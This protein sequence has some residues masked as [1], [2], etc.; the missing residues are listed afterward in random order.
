MKVLECFAFWL[1]LAVALAIF[2]GYVPPYHDTLAMLS[3]GV[4][5][6]L[7][8]SG[9]RIGSHMQIQSMAIVFLLNYAF[10]PAITLAPAILMNDNAYWTGFVIMVSMPPA[11]AL[12][13][14][15]KILKADTELAMSGEVFLYLASL[16]M[17]P[18]MI[19]MLAGKSVSI[20]PVVWSLFTLIL[21]P[22]GV[23]RV[24]GR[25]I[26]A[27]SGWVK[28]TINV[29]FF[30][31]I[32]LVFSMNRAMIIK[33]M[34]SVPVIGAICA[35]RTL[36][37]SL[38]VLALCVWA[39]VVGKRALTY[40]LFSSLK[41]S[42]LAMIIAM[43]AFS[44]KTALPAAVAVFFEFFTVTFLEALSKIFIAQG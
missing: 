23:S 29:M 18:L 10:L 1:F 13:P 44:P 41:N 7:A 15:S 17:A 9:I 14:F 38:A 8:M 4:A 22:M 11:V 16:A 34:E 30:I 37:I 36:G 31:L 25:V 5:M 20:M 21:L 28:I 42:G 12:I 27:E 40:S 43:T 3:L 32:Y 39:G 19:Y 35:L 2:L 26:D 24:M 6:T 33:S